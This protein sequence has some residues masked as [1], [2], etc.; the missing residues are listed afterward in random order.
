LRE[1]IFPLLFADPAREFHL[2]EATAVKRRSAPA[3][4]SALDFFLRKAKVSSAVRAFLKSTP[5]L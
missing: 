5:F 3:R 1:A 2:R 4:V